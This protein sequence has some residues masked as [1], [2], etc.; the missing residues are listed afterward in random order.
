MLSKEFW[1]S[2]DLK[3]LVLPEEIR[4]AKT[5]ITVSEGIKDVNNIKV[6]YREA[7]PVQKCS[8]VEVLLLHGRMFSSKTWLDLSTIHLIAAMGYRAVAVDLPGYANTPSADINNKADFLK[9]LIQCFELSH[10]VIVSPSMSGFYTLPYLINY[11]KDI[12]G[13]IPVAP[14]GIEVLENQPSCKDLSIVQYVYEPL[15]PFL[16]EPLPDLQSIQTPTMVVFG[17]KDRSRS[18]ALLSL[19]PMSQCQEIPNGNHPAYLDDPD[20]WHQL[21]YNFLIHVSKSIA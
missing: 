7:L 21:L 16:Y 8:P 2:I 14:V 19:L 10:S 1:N 3:K 11:W 12:A 9:S 4:L 20:L 5:D 18:S 15:R 17:E 13:Y 6:F